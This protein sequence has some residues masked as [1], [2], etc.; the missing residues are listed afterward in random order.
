MDE[1]IE[2]E[3]IKEEKFPDKNCVECGNPIPKPDPEKC[4]TNY[5][6]WLRRKY[7]NPDCRYK[8]SFRKLKQR[9]EKKRITKRKSKCQPLWK[10]YLRNTENLRR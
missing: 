4:C 3:K 7:C 6:N 10:S 2:S 9:N 1:K 5:Y 8:A